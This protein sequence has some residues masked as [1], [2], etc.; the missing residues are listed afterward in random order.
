MG[1]KH[2]SGYAFLSGTSM[3]CPYATG[4]VALIKSA[5]PDWFLAAIRSA[6]VTTGE[7]HSV[8]RILQDVQFKDQKWFK[9]FVSQS[10]ARTEERLRGSG[11]DI[12]AARMG[13]KLNAAG[14][15]SKQMGGVTGWVVKYQENLV[16][17]GV[18]ESLAQVCSKSGAMDPLMNAYVER[19]QA[20]TRKW[21][22]NILEAEK[23]QPPK[24]TDDGR[25]YTL[26]AVD[27]FRILG[28]QVQIAHET[29]IDIMLYNIVT[30]QTRPYGFS[31]VTGQ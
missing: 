2:G 15:I 1:T 3:A 21:Y 11:D 31:T 17:L 9:Q 6:L 10:K 18:D 13:A 5:H 19:M 25:L 30:T 28:K 20:T 4:I 23:V 16:S 8:N 27:L 26:V 14:W 29:N 24:K 12:V 7:S 22:L